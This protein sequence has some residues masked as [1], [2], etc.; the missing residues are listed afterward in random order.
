[1]ILLL[2]IIFVKELLIYFYMT[3]S[4]LSAMSLMTWLS[5]RLVTTLV[6]NLGADPACDLD[7]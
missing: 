2:S 1:M 3:A 7:E 4:N 5:K 6:G